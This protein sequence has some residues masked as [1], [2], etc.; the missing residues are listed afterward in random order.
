M[1][2]PRSGAAVSTR[3][4]RPNADSRSY[5]A[6]RT[7]NHLILDMKINNKALLPIQKSRALHDQSWKIFLLLASRRAQVLFDAT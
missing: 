7:Q 4:S 3:S 2:Q 5:A 6:S 1:I